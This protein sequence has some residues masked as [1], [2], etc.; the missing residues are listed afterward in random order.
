MEVHPYATIFPLLSGDEFKSLCDDVESNGLRVPV[1]T[2][3]GKILDGRNRA[4][5]CEVC[6]VLMRSEE[7]KGT[8]LEA[9]NE[10]MSLNQHRRHLTSSQ[11][12]AAAVK[13]TEFMEAAKKS[14]RGRMAEA[15]KSSAPGKPAEKGVEIVPH[16]STPPKSRD[17]AAKPFGTNGKYI[18]AAVKLKESSPELLERVHSG[19]LTIPEAKREAARREKTVV[20]E[21]RAKEAETAIFGAGDRHD[22]GWEIITGDCLQVMAET[23]VYRPR[24]IFA[25][26][27]Y[28]IGV[29]YGDHYD[30]GRTDDDYL[31]WAMSWIREATKVLADDGSFWLL[32]SDEYAAEYGCLI[33][34]AG[35]TLRSWIIWYESF[36]VNCTHKFNRTHRHLF[37]AV[38]HPKQ[39]T[40]NAEAVSRASDRLT[41]YNDSRANPLGKVWDDVWGINPAIP[42][43]VDNDRERIP[44]F[45][46][47]LPLSLLRPI[48]EC[49]TLPGDLVFDP[50]N[51]SGTTGAACLSA[52]HDGKP[53]PRRYVGVELSDHFAALARTRLMALTGE[54]A[55]AS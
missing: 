17:V 20:M 21:A 49:S 52:R 6:D 43:V 3:Q 15:G 41:K 45:P 27:P 4:R 12:A 42:R 30:D 10:V 51:G 37:Y 44:G 24:L 35:L 54:L 32:V 2:Y 39:F 36:G 13:A 50:F 18:D 47:Q 25:D 11:G 46:T 22:I 7:F 26:P 29:E 34:D 19:E 38:K 55:N 9:I 8:D 40:F 1:L 5:A 28:N 16:L 23:E 53:A 31:D 33:K 14:A 48:V